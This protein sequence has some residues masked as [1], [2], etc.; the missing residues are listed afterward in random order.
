[1]FIP[2][3]LFSQHTMDLLHDNVNCNNMQFFDW[4]RNDEEKSEYIMQIDI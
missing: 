4:N 2:S 1:M 3:L